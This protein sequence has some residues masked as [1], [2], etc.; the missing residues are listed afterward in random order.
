MREKLR[1]DGGASETLGT[2]LQG[3]CSGKN[4][5]VHRSSRTKSRPLGM[6]SVIAVGRAVIAVGRA[7]IDACVGGSARVRKRARLLACKHARVHARVRA[8]LP[9]CVRACVRACARARVRAC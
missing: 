4:K 3:Q 8:C 1:A 6:R 2:S 9:G 5:V 7:V